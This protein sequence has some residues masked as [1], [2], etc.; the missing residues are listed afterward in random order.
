MN[1][2]WQFFLTPSRVPKL[3]FDKC[4]RHRSS[5]HSDNKILPEELQVKNQTF[6][7]LICLQLSS[8]VEYV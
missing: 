2:K 8:L 6:S 4:R 5:H 1:I 7:E 3:S